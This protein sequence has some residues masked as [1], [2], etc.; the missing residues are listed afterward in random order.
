MLLAAGCGGEERE[1]APKLPSGL[2]ESLAARSDA[3]ASRLDAGDA[4]AA[5]TEADALQRAAIAAVNEQR[6]PAALQEEL[7][8]AATALAAAIR[9]EPAAAPAGEDE[10]GDS[11]GKSKGKGKGKKNGTG[12]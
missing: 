6:V 12:T 11:K 8:G 4:C 3:V 9:C 1:P 5:R 7:L 10:D 2:A